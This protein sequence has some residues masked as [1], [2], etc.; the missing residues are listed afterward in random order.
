[1]NTFRF[2]KQDWLAALFVTLFVLFIGA[3]TLTKGVPDWGDDFAAYMSEGMAIADG[4]FHEQ[5]VRNYTMHPSPL[6]LEA[7]EDGLVY[8]W[9]Y[10][11]MLSGIY[12]LTG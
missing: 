9:G 8:V 1:M 11:L 4:E 12:K 5:T 10:P 2:T 3:A 6:T 7:S